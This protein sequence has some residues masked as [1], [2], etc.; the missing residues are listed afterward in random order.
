MTTTWRDF[1]TADERYTVLAEYDDGSAIC[2]AGYAGGGN[3][4]GLFGEIT[5]MKLTADG[6]I[7]F[8]SYDS[9]TD[10][11]APVVETASFH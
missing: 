11:E 8:R 9:T 3:E 5:L 6:S 4:K 7:F 1:V 10:W 2:L